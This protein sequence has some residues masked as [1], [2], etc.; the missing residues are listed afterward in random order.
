M[1]HVCFSTNEYPQH[2]LSWRNKKN[3]NNFLL[4]KWIIWSGANTLL[5]GAL[6]ALGKVCFPTKRCTDILISNQKHIWCKNY[7]MFWILYHIRPNYHTVHL[8]FS[9]ILGKLAVKYVPTCTYTKGTL[10]K[11]ISKELIKRCLCDVFALFT[12]FFLIFFIKRVCCGY[13]FELHRQ[14]DAIQMGTH[15]ICLY[16]EVDEK[17]TDY[18][19][20]I[21]GI[22]WLCTYRGM[23]GN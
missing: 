20:K 22:A 12:F 19:L 17:Y 8:G 18:N 14:V 16:K 13:S 7:M 23:W 21:Y 10:K 2:M 4:E 9:K 3:I 15:N 5:S 1:D 6:R 11:K